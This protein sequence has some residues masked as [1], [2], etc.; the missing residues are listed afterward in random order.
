[1]EFSTK[2]RVY[3]QR[4]R[5]SQEELGELVDVSQNQVSRWERGEG[6]PNIHQGLAIAHAIGVR[7][8]FLVDDA[9]DEQPPGLDEGE[10]SLIRMFRAMRDA[11]ALD[12]DE[13]MR[14]LALEGPGAPAHENPSPSRTPGY[15]P[16][17]EGQDLTESLKREIREAGRA[18]KKG[19]HHPDIEIGTPLKGGPKTP[20][21]KK[22]AG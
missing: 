5:L 15:W 13:A 17:R 16:A 18:K 7:V 12:A 3:R 1:M 21:R 14:R 4:A 9:L 22:G 19:D 8:E 2:L 20:Q 6:T 10:R 11:G